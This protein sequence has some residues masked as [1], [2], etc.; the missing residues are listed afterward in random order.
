MVVEG[1]WHVINPHELDK[2]SLSI[3][4]YFFFNQMIL[5]EKNS[6]EQKNHAPPKKNRGLSSQKLYPFITYHH[7]TFFHSLLLALFLHTFII[8]LPSH[9]LYSSSSPSLTPPPTNLHQT[10]GTINPPHQN[11]HQTTTTILLPPWPFFWYPPHF[12]SSR[13]IAIFTQSI[14]S[15]LNL[16]LVTIFLLCI[17]TSYGCCWNVGFAILIFSLKKML[18]LKC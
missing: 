9:N 3:I 4:I 14:N 16:R 17:L 8:N 10:D 13:R 1:S 2:I 18:L 5:D 6:I 12:S 15:G 11:Q 7:I